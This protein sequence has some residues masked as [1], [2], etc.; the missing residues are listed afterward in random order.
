MA[1]IT[2]KFVGS[3]VAVTGGGQQVAYRLMVPDK[4]TANLSTIAMEAQRW[5]ATHN[6][7]QELVNK[8]EL[9]AS[10]AR[11][12]QFGEEVLAVI[13]QNVKLG[14]CCSLIAQASDGRILGASSYTWWAPAGGGLN[15]QVIDPAHLAGSPGKDQL[16]GIGT[17]L[18]A[19]VAQ[20]ML[21]HGVT[22]LYLHPLDQAAAVFWSHRGF[23]PCGVGGR[24]CIQGQEGIRRLIS[25]C[26]RLP[27]CQD[28]GEC[29]LCG[30][31][32]MTEA[33]RLPQNRGM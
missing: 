25:S 26:F 17:A 3:G 29:L 10:I 21:D 18:V 12:A 9:D 31:M 6:R 33:F 22:T 23:V 7:Y 5:R 15:L 28:N 24:M 32:K 27:G 19:A 8:H 13:G 4:T 16:R 11:R 2:G 14:V 1:A 30:T 20:Q